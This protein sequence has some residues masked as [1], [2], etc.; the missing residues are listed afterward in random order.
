VVVPSVLFT[1]QVCGGVVGAGELVGTGVG[2]GAG[3]AVGEGDTVGIGVTTGV[4]VG[5]GRGA[6][7]PGALLVTAVVAAIRQATAPMKMRDDC[8]QRSRP[9]PESI[10]AGGVFMI[11]L[12][13]SVVVP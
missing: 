11:G 1:S 9:R 10:S 5:L 2:L 8:G 6:A 12:L 7:H 4:G 3:E 13:E